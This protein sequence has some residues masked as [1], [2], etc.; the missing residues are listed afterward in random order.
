VPGY[1]WPLA[2]L[3]CPCQSAAVLLHASHTYRCETSFAVALVPRWSRPWRESTTFRR[4]VLGT[5][6]RGLPVV[7]SQC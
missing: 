1:L 7:V 4:S 5:Y 6:G 2:S 3:A